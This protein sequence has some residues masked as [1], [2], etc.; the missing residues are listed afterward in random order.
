MSRIHL[1]VFPDDA[2][3]DHVAAR[4]LAWAEAEPT[5][6]L[7]LPTGDT[8]RPVYAKVA[9]AIDLGHSAIVLLDEFCL[10]SGD[11]ARCDE[12]FRR[13]LLSRLSISPG[14]VHMFDPQARDLNAECERIDRVVNGKLDLTV[15]GLGGNGHLG[16]NEPGS[17]H[18]DPTRVVELAGITRIAATD[19]YGSASEPECGL[20]LGMGPILAS[21]EIWL[22]VT[23]A[24]KAGILARAMNG[25]IG[26]HI[27]ASFLQSHPN[28]TVFADESAAQEPVGGGQR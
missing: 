18:D 3:A 9:P 20:T 26:P 1:E 22:L 13:D 7:C 4:W 16:L 2:W 21:R 5:A 23:G 24:H 11:P 12:V 17:T 27:P 25:P 14:A 6:R 19:R 28:V 10:P 15:L 8:P